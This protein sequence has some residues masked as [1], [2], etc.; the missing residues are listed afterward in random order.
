MRDSSVF[1]LRYYTNIPFNKQSFRKRMADELFSRIKPVAIV[2][3]GTNIGNTT[4]YFA[5]KQAPLFGIEFNE[6]LHAIS[7]I[8]L[9]HLPHVE[10][11]QGDSVDVMKKRKFGDNNGIVFFYLDAHWYNNLP[12]KEEMNLVA[13]DYDRF[14]VM[15]DDFSV[16]DDTD[17][18]FDTYPGIGSLSLP[19]IRNSLQKEFGY[20]YPA[21]QGINED[22]FRRGAIVICD[23]SSRQ[24]LDGVETLRPVN[25]TFVHAVIAGEVTS[26]EGGNAAYH[27]VGT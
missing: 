14:V 2:E 18:G 13:R 7:S 12:L 26:I 15:I 9:N 24:L 11:I 4:Q 20:Y 23:P 10:I 25:T 22:S 6:I 16:H 19:Y 1:H 3:T 8:R 27:S 21:C 5:T 17:Y